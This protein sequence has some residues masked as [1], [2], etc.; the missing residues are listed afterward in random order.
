LEFSAEFK[1]KVA[2]VAGIGCGIG[3]MLGD[4]GATVYC[5]GRSLRGLPSELHR[6]DT[7]EETAEM[8]PTR[9]GIG[10]FVQLDH[11]NQ[12]QVTAL[13]EYLSEE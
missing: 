9:G 7:M 5:S 4:A 6:P 3:C 11:T 10:I 13:Y 12:E 2:L 8:L 1:G